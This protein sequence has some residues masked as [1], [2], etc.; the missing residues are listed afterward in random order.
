ML[1][2]LLLS[3]FGVAIAAVHR[4]VPSRLERDFGVLPALGAHSR[5]HLATWCEASAVLGRALRSSR[6]TASRAALRL[7]RVALRAEEFLLVGAKVE[8]DATI[9]TLKCLVLGNHTG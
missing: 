5:E 6:L 4:S 3:D 1:V 2:G 9:D 8:L 7:V